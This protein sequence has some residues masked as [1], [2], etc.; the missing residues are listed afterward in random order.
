MTLSR[1]ALIALTVLATAC[2]YHAP[3]SP[4]STPPPTPLILSAD[5]QLGQGEAVGQATI[6]VTARTGGVATADLAVAFSASAGTVTPA[7]ATTDTRGI[8]TTTLTGDPG[9]VTVTITAA[10]VTTKQMVALQPKDSSSSALGVGIAIRPATV[11]E[12]A[13]LIIES[14]NCQ[15]PCLKHATFGD[16]TTYDG[17]ASTVFNTY[18]TAGDFPVSVEITDGANRRASASATAHVSAAPPPPVNRTPLTLTVGCTPQPSGVPTPCTATAALAGVLLSSGVTY[19]W[20]FG[21]GINPT[22]TAASA[23]HAYATGGTFHVTV[24]ATKDTG[25]T[26]SVSTSVVVPALTVTLSCTQPAPGAALGCNISAA[27]ETGI[28]V[29]SQVTNVTWDWGDGSPPTSTLTTFS[30]HPYPQPN[31]WLVIATAAGAGGRTGRVSKMITV[32]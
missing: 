13:E 25:E 2:G 17:Y 16:G 15:L 30:S 23:A 29:T 8:A 31:D 27:D 32:Q 11:G 3:T 5:T 22:T 28:V 1:S 12:P 19:A 10:G 26:G 18:R 14:R 9:A 6:T 20:T 4:S 21:E 7:S 24:N